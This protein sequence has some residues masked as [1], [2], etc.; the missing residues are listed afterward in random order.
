MPGN[1]GGAPP[2]KGNGGGGK[3]WP[4]WFWGSIGLA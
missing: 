2:G 3:P 4:G 1:G